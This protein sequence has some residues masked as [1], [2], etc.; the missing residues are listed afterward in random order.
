MKKIICFTCVCVFVFLSS[1]LFARN[2]GFCGKILIS[3]G[4]TKLK[5]LDNCG[6]PVSIYSEIKEGTV[7][8]V[9]SQ[10][11]NAVWVYKSVGSKFFHI[12]FN[13]NQV[14]KTKE[15]KYSQTYPRHISKTNF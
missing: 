7:V 14:L 6:L 4:F 11:T 5:V 2:N 15:E 3:K 12:Y 13:E 10:K 9:V 8:D 1:E